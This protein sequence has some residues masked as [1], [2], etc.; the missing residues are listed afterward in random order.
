MNY[1][2][3]FPGDYARVTATL[4]LAEHGAYTLLLDTYYGNESPLPSDKRSLYRICRAMEKED[5][6]AVDSI[7]KQFFFKGE[8]G[9]L[10]NKRADEEIPKAHVRIKAAQSNGKDGGR[11]KKTPLGSDEETH[12]DSQRV[13]D[14]IPT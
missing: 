1:Y 4:S 2:S 3:R 9:L 11:P 14:G 10:H 7:I 13:I 12:R 8:D 5:K 6:E